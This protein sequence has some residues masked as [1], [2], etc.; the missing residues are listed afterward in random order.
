MKES[1]P[2]K[3]EIQYV[4]MNFCEKCK[5]GEEVENDWFNFWIMQKEGYAMNCFITKIKES[6]LPKPENL[7]LLFRYKIQEMNPGST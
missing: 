5:K 1:R 4:K 3:I 7:Q 2:E 6:D